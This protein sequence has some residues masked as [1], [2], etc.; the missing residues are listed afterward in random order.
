MKLPKLPPQ[1][2]LEGW[3][4]AYS[5]LDDIGV[6]QVGRY[7]H[8]EQIRRH[9]P[10]KGLTI[11]QWWF[12]IHLNRRPLQKQIALTTVDG[13]NHFSFAMTESVQSLAHEID[14]DASGSL[15]APEAITNTATQERYLIRSLI[16]EA[17]TSSQLEG[18]VATAREA[19]QLVRAGRKPRNTSEQMVLNNYH[20]MMFIRERRNATLTMDLVH[21][22]HAIITSETL[23]RPADAGRLRSADD[24]IAVVDHADGTV[25]HEPPAASELPA[26]LQAMC[27]FANGKNEG[28]VHPVVRA[29][30][31]H[32]WLGHDHPFCDG[33]GRTARAL[34][35]WSM[36]NQGYWMAEFISISRI[37]KQAPTQ[38]VH[39]YLYSETWPYDATHFLIH[40]LQTITRAIEDLHRY[41]EHKASEVQQIEKLLHHN[42]NLN[43]RQLALL[44]KALRTPDAVFTLKSHMTT[45]RIAHETSRQDLYKLRDMGLLEQ[46]RR[47]R[48]LE[49]SPVP[50]LSTCLTSA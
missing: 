47:G 42:R 33:N 26:R 12:A 1:R 39:S 19:K 10:P 45:H 7:L 29:I 8:W 17:L 31:I 48:Q 40:Q 4:I 41:L 15:R 34:F 20:A 50:E 28:F 16:E 5:H 14:R 13:E 46:R 30:L 6:E 23:D 2:P 36:L 44:S 27:D 18:A 37:L 43:H 21:E 24:D 11:E 35:Y 38:Y 32:F 9:N 3:D 49:F 22:L 25:L